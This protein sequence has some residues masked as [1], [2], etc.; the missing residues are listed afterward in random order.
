M[1]TQD[2]VIIREGI[3]IS[4]WV[5]IFSIAMQA[6]FLII[7]KWDYTVLLGNLLSATCAILNF[8]LLGATLQRALSS[9][10]EKYVKNMMRLSQMLRLLF[11]LCVAVLGATLPFLNLWA[12][13]IPLFFTRIAIMLRPLFNK[14]MGTEANLDINGLSSGGFSD[15]QR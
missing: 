15:E 4:I 14:I 2:K 13:V 6:V 8:L 3:Y 11:V 5:L 10:D 7:G 9:D 1:S 12:T